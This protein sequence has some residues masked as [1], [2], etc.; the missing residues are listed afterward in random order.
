M[1]NVLVH[2]GGD[3]FTAMADQSSPF[4]DT[5]AGDIRP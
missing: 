5:I 4:M 3:P 1:E 2:R